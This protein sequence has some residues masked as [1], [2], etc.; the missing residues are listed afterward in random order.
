MPNKN[1]KEK[2]SPKAGKSGKS[3]KE[4]QDIIES[5]R[6]CLRAGATEL[7]ITTE[8]TEMLGPSLLPPKDPR[9]NMAY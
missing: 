9:G 5:E 7:E 1:K 8:N 6:Y 2:E 4:G 3:S